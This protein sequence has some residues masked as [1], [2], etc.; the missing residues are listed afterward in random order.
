MLVRSQDGQAVVETSS[1]WIQPSADKTRHYI[2]AATEFDPGGVCLGQY[3]SAGAAIAVLTRVMAN[4]EKRRPTDLYAE[5]VDAVSAEALRDAVERVT[6]H[7][8]DH[9]KT[10]VADQ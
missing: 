1:V 4:G 6:M 2:F 3:G 7:R 5:K 8:L 10:K 9:L